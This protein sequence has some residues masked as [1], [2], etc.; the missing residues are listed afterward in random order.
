[1]GPWAQP[2]SLQIF[3]WL[4]T[5]HLGIS[6]KVLGIGRNVIMISVKPDEKI[7]VWE[8]DLWTLFKVD[9]RKLGNAWN[10]GSFLGHMIFLSPANWNHGLWS[11]QLQ[12]GEHRYFLSSRNWPES[13][14]YNWFKMKYNLQKKTMQFVVLEL[15][16]KANI[17]FAL[18]FY[19][20][21]NLNCV[22]M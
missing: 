1:M 7:C 11:S 8:G 22:W 13:V 17:F 4:K 21:E 18:L 6:F 19:G 20:N 9:C 15:G 3:T 12:F 2:P 5:F 14:G 16:V 10:Y